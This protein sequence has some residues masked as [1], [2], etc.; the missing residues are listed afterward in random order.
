[1]Q[2]ESTSCWVLSSGDLVTGWRMTIPKD[3]PGQFSSSM[4]YVGPWALA[5]LVWAWPRFWHFSRLLFLPPQENNLIISHLCP[6]Q[7]HHTPNNPSISLFLLFCRRF[8][9]RGLFFDTSQ[10]SYHTSFRT[11]AF[12]SSLRN[13]TL[14]PAFLRTRERFTSTNSSRNISTPTLAC[15]VFEIE[16]SD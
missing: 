14:L 3:G 8:S 4:I 1:M 5:N 9:V 10:S 2:R 6:S 13:F 7:K 11:R 15:L 16:R 12:S